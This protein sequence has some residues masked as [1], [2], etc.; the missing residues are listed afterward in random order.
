MRQS[1]GWGQGRGQR[2]RGG[3]GERLRMGKTGKEHSNSKTLFYEDCKSGSARNPSEQPVLAKLLM[4]ENK[5]TG[6]HL[7]T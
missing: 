2:S 5:I 6:Q 3:G 1:G 4:D 7:Q